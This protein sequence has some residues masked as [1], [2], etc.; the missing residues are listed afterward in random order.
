MRY[1]YQ[2]M[3]QPSTCSSTRVSLHLKESFILYTHQLVVVDSLLR[4]SSRMD[5]Y[6]IKSSDYREF[7]G[8]YHTWKLYD[9]EFWGSLLLR[10]NKW[11]RLSAD[12][13]QRLFCAQH[14]KSHYRYEVDATIHRTRRNSPAPTEGFPRSLW[15]MATR[16]GRAWLQNTP[17]FRMKY[18]QRR[19]QN[20][21]EVNGWNM[22]DPWRLQNAS[23][24]H[25]SVLVCG[26]NS[27]IDC[28]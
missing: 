14:F 27:T 17:K 20:C 2:N 7:G 4:S 26:E 5:W 22:Y 8:V 1:I 16:Y 12:C 6:S 24:P 15:I 21:F 25:A 3:L 28:S 9:R 19:L 13:S 23:R 10:W 18:D 11:T